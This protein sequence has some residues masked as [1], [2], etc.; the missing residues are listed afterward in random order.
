MPRRDPAD[1]LRRAAQAKSRLRRHL[2]VA[3]ALTEAMPTRPIVVGGTAEDFWTRDD[4]HVTDLDLCMPLG[5]DARTV[6]RQ[7]G[8]VREGRHWYHAEANVAVEVPDSLVDR[9]PERFAVVRVDGTPV[10]VIGVA[11]LYL[12]RVRQATASDVESVSFF[13]ALAIATDRFEEIDW[14]YVARRL[15]E[16]R[17]MV[18]DAMRRIDRKV[19]RR[20]RAAILGRGVRA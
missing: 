2:L 18:G 9:D 1:L 7:L 6:F 10:T 17:G 15:R 16:E 13:S 12:N 11:D 5:A 20:A 3:A 8:F 19:R 14:R 4:Y